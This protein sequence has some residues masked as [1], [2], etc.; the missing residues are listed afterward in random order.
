VRIGAIPLLG[1]LNFPFCEY[2]E[3]VPSIA[4]PDPS[5]LTLNLNSNSYKLQFPKIPGDNNNF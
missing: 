4:Q 2:M 5:T 1:T 3:L